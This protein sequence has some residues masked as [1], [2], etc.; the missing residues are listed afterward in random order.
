MLQKIS[1]GNS[2]KMLKKLL[3]KNNEFMCFY[4]LSKQ[5]SLYLVASNLT[6]FDN[7]NKIVSNKRLYFYN[8]YFFYKFFVNSYILLWAR[9]TFRGKGFR[10]R[11]FQEDKKLTLNFGHSHWDRIKFYKYWSFWK[12]RRQSYVIVTT[13]LLNLWY[14]YIELLKI[15]K[16]YNK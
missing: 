3:I 13:N 2:L 7:F 8:F 15:L 12:I 10:I 11:N 16:I 4:I 1:I 14:L 9:I 6:L 5:T